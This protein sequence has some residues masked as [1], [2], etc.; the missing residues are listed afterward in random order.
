MTTTTIRAKDL[1]AGD[2]VKSITGNILTVSKVDKTNNKVIV[3]FD[4]DL[5][6]DFGH[7]NEVTIVSK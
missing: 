2:Q 1:K 3:I 4:G 5:E 7:Y 6:I